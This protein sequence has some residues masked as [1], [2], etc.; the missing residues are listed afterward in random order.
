[1]HSLTN[2][3]YNIKLKSLMKNTKRIAWTSLGHTLIEGFF[4]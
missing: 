3:K 1:M 2:I 4:T